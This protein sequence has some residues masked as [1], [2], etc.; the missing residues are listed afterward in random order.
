MPTRFNLTAEQKSKLYEKLVKF[1]LS[2]SDR[3]RTS[4]GTTGLSSGITIEMIDEFYEEAHTFSSVE[5][6]EE[7]H[8][9]FSHNH[10]VAFWIIECTS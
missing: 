10:A 6:I 7:R 3:G 9:V 5:D 1:R 2:Q 4:V 8:P